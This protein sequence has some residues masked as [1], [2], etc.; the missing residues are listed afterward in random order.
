MASWLVGCLQHPR[1][2]KTVSGAPIDALSVDLP[3]RC[4]EVGQERLKIKNTA[5]LRGAYVTLSHRWT[6]KT[7]ACNTTADNLEERYDR[8]YID[9]WSKAFQDAVTVTRHLGIPYLWIDSLCIIQSGDNGRDWKR[10]ALKMSQYY[11]HSVFTIAA[12]NVSEHGFLNPPFT[13][14]REELVR[15]PYRD[16]NGVRRGFFYISRNESA[17]GVAGKYGKDILN[18]PLL[19]RGWIFQEWLLSRRV[20]H[21]LGDHIFFECQSRDPIN[22]FGESVRP[23]DLSALRFSGQSGD[24]LEPYSLR[25]LLAEDATASADFWFR[26]V[27]VYSG[28]NLTRPESDRIRALAGLAAEFREIVSVR[29]S[30][31]CQEPYL[32]GCWLRDL[33]RSLLWEQQDLGPRRLLSP[34]GA[35]WSWAASSNP[36][37]WRPARAKVENACEVLDILSREESEDETFPSPS[38]LRPA[39]VLARSY[40]VDNDFACLLLR[41][42]IAL[43]LNGPALDD[44]ERERI[45]RYTGVPN[46]ET[47]RWTSIADPANPTGHIG[48]AD[49]EFFHRNEETSLCRERR[50]LLALHVCTVRIEEGLRLGAIDASTEAHCVLF[51][52]PVGTVGEPGVPQ[53]V[54]AGTGR[55]Y[56]EDFFKQAEEVALRLV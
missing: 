23:G 37:H 31:R 10:E 52:T 6:R 47:S 40:N 17:F 28:M 24:G 43:V 16:R 15:L 48:W 19:H 44:S 51:L 34:K 32:A 12:S 27:Q 42:K 4:I 7:A 54:R 35:T 3:T 39:E 45:A 38:P 20:I 41:G 26:I 14:F 29:H 50:I 18:G 30:D 11:Q 9:G 5:G 55:I 2:N 1:C 36:V 46:E 56:K 25:A 13:E 53:Y 21:F 8:L 22:D 33:Q 49:V